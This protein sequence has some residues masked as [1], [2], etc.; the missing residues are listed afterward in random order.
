M[1]FIV[2]LTIFYNPQYCDLGIIH[3][4]IAK[5]IDRHIAF[6]FLVEVKSKLQHIKNKE[7]F[8][9]LLIGS[10]AQA[11]STYPNII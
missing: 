1:E 7:Q 4:L 6:S 10:F 8:K 3:R 5:K 2:L 11:G 9:K